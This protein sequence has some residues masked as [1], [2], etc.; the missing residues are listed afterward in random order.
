[1]ENTPVCAGLEDEYVKS[2]V[3]KPNCKSVY[4]LNLQKKAF[5]LCIWIWGNEL[6]LP[7]FINDGND[8]VTKRSFPPNFQA[9]TGFKEYMKASWKSTNFISS[10]IVKIRNSLKN[11]P[12]N[13]D[14]TGRYLSKIEYTIF[15]YTA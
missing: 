10:Q 14:F 3:Y 11:K 7:S 9:W 1:M 12:V 2:K 8:A 6:S 5:A 13:L 15:Q 4:Q